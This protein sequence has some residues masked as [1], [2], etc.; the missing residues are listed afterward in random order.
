[1]LDVSVGCRLIKKITSNKKIII[2]TSGMRGAL[3]SRGG[4][5]RH[6]KMRERPDLAGGVNWFMP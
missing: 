5:K 1:M 3:R 2:I 6:G 4:A